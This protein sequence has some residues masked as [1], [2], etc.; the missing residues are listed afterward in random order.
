ME[1]QIEEFFNN[2]NLLDVYNGLTSQSTKD[3]ILK[4]VIDYRKGCDRNSDREVIIT[5]ITITDDNVLVEI[6]DEYKQRFKII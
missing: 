6:N 4:S 5:D 2:S 1:Y 3:K